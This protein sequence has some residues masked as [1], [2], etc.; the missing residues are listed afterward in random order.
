MLVREV[1]DGVGVGG[2]AAQRVEVVEVAAQDRDALRLQGRRGA[3]GPGETDD[4]V[5]GAE[6]LVDGGGPD[7]PAGSGDE[8][9][10]L[11]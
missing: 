1:G 9:T 6:Q 7:P 4:L 2:A 11:A 8:Y 5:T 3:V 10:H